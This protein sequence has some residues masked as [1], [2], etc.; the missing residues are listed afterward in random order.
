MLGRSGELFFTPEDNAA[1]QP[2]REITTARAHGA[3]ADE[4][5]HLRADGSRFWANGELQP[6]RENGAIVGYVK[7]LRDRTEQHEMQTRLE[8]MMGEA[9][10]A[11][12]RIG[13]DEARLRE[14]FEAAPGFI[15]V[16]RGRDFRFEFVNASY[17]RLVAGRARI[18]GTLL[19]AVPELAGQ[20]G[21]GRVGL[22][23]VGARFR[24][25]ADAGLGAV[26]DA[27]TG[28]C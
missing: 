7:I 6:L 25:S 19:E 3:A 21:E 22:D 11:R 14:M 20:G 17:Q 12:D 26:E 5:W 10:A 18:G 28:H 23:E 1:G 24:E 2:E 27:L 4:R 9:A 16:F 15:A 13:A 8:A